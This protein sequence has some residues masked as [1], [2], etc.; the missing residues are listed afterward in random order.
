VYTGNREKVNSEAAI[1]AERLRA[2][3]ATIGGLCKEYSCAYETMRRAVLTQM[4]KDEYRRL[5]KK[6]LGRGGVESRFKKGIK[7]W[8][9]GL[10]FQAGGRSSETQ[11]KKGHLPG[12]HQRKGTISIRKIKSGKHVRM[13]KV[14][15]IVDG[16]HK[17]I[18]YAVYVWEQA[19]GPIPEG[20]FPVHDDGDLLNDDPA[21]LKITDRA[22]HLAN[23]RKNNPKVYKK[24]AKTRKRKTKK[25]R[26]EHER[27]EKIRSQQEK[28]EK[29]EEQELRGLIEQAVTRQGIRKLKGNEIVITECVG[30]GYEPED[31]TV[32]K[33]PKCG[34]ITFETFKQKDMKSINEMILEGAA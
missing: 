15:G 25:R 6:R 12:N 3:T 33:C 34:C 20:M 21:N 11:F 8:N 24:I 29:Q 5:A 28:Q 7:P 22:G 19:N 23:M 9:K 30:C 16:Q 4:T 10:H 32:E 14:S 26:R 2:G 1:I 27:F 17:W 18:P 31:E 13:I